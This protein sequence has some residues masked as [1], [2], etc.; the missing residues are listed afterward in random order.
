[1]PEKGGWPEFHES[2]PAYLENIEDGPTCGDVYWGRKYAQRL[3]DEGVSAEVLGSIRLDCSEDLAARWP[4]IC[5]IKISVE[6]T[7]MLAICRWLIENPHTH[8]L[9]HTIR[10]VRRYSLE[11]ELDALYLHEELRKAKSD[12]PDETLS[13]MG[14][15]AASVRHEANRKRTEHALDWYKLH[16][17]EFPNK[18]EA[19]VA[20]AEFS[21][22]AVATA[23]KWLLNK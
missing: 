7:K 11:R 3:I 21:H 9:P 14:R 19:A 15:H 23:R 22:V 2:M 6:K 17:H 8:V 16:K 5:S 1:M 10:A 4:V 13:R 20:I 18:D 12:L